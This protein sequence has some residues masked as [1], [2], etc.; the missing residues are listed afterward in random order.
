MAIAQCIRFALMF[1]LLGLS[2]SIGMNILFEYSTAAPFIVTVILILGT[3]IALKKV[4]H[5]AKLEGAK[6]NPQYDPPS[7]LGSGMNVLTFLIVI[8]AA[9]M[10]TFQIS[11]GAGVALIELLVF[12]FIIVRVLIFVFGRIVIQTRDE[13]AAKTA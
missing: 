6:P 2:Y 10:I 4:K 5:A 13:L 12:G 3:Y 9:I 7:L 11:I 8:T 1:A